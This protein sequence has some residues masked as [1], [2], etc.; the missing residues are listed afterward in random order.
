[1]WVDM[2]QSVE[3]LER[4]KWAEKGAFALYWDIHLLPSDIRAPASQAF[5]LRLGL[6]IVG[7]S[8]SQASGFGLELYHWLSWASSWQTADG[9]TSQ[10][11]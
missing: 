4:K 3:S 9:G 8:G 1:M 5:R 2:V 10:P 7:S 11:P 6:N